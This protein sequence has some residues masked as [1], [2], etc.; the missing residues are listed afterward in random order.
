MKRFSKILT[1]GLVSATALTGAGFMLSGCDI[2]KSSDEQNVEEQ[3]VV[4]S[5]SVDESTLPSYIIKDKFYRTNIKMLVTY[6]DGT[7]KTVD[8]T[9]SMFDEADKEKL[10]IEGNQELTVRYKDKTNTINVT[11]VGTKYLLKEVWQNN[12]NT[13]LTTTISGESIEGESIENTFKI[14]RVNKQIWQTVNPNNYVWMENGVLYS[15]KGGTCYKYVDGIVEWE[16]QLNAIN[17]DYIEDALFENGS[18]EHNTY[19]IVSIEKEDDKYILTANVSSKTSTLNGTIKYIFNDDFLL[20]V[21]VN[22]GFV[23]TVEYSYAPITDSIPSEMK[24]LKNKSK[25]ASQES[26]EL[27]DTVIKNSLTKDMSIES[28]HISNGQQ[29]TDYV[30]LDRD[31]KIF[32]STHN[33][34]TAYVWL[35]TDGTGGNNGILY[36]HIVGSNQCKAEYNIFQYDFMAN[37]S[38]LYYDANI[39]DEGYRHNG[40]GKH[41]LMSLERDDDK[42]I[43]T[44]SHI[45][46]NGEEKVGILKYTYN[47]QYL[48]SVE[49]IDEDGTLF[50]KYDYTE[51]NIQISDDIKLLAEEATIDEE[52]SDTIAGLLEFVLDKC[53]KDDIRFTVKREIE[54]GGSTQNYEHTVTIDRENDVF[55]GSLTEYRWLDGNTLYEYKYHQGELKCIKRNNANYSAV[56]NEYT[57]FGYHYDMI[58]EGA[59]FNGDGNY[60]LI[61][62]T[63]LDDEVYEVV[64]E[65]QYTNGSNIQ[66]YY[67][68]TKTQILEVQ[69]TG[70]ISE[71]GYDNYTSIIMKYEYFSDIS[72]EVPDNIKVLQDTAIEG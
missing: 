63:A 20:K 6:D 24:Q 18:S 65:A 29:Q 14:D 49:Y 25:I 22:Y 58:N 19:S 11:V 7:S 55:K 26:L 51:L 4:T 27:F 46:I 31:N 16:N 70:D 53:S 41:K 67:K 36:T 32:M 21:E 42:Y 71:L 38:S 3:K 33:T 52:D 39:T 30:Q 2:F 34:N 54:K 59:I 69:I 28:T 61:R 9:E 66:Y 60:K 15:I 50:N 62:Q 23:G 48:L 72:L 17:F 1:L 43:L 13:D 37:E 45:Y 47:D 57:T 10:K 56:A 68:F 5:I 40:Y 44:T 12:I 64:Y 35:E 8:V